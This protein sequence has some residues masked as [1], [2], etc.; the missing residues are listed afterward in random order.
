[1]E[2][3]AVEHSNMSQLKSQI[4]S[5]K[6]LIVSQKKTLEES[7]HRVKDVQNTLDGN[8]NNA[9]NTALI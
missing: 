3:E 4:E 9:N 2:R 8:P 5:L 7:R 6:R 1:M